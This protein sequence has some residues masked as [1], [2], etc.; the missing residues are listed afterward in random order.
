MPPKS[1]KNVFAP[2]QCIEDARQR[3]GPAY[4][5]LSLMTCTRNAVE[6]T[7]LVNT[8]EDIERE[9]SKVRKKIDREKQQL[10][11][12]MKRSETRDDVEVSIQRCDRAPRTPDE[13]N[14]L[15][16]SRL[17]KARGECNVS[18]QASQSFSVM[19]DRDL[20]SGS[21]HSQRSQRAKSAISAN[22]TTE[23]EQEELNME[24][25]Y[26][27]QIEDLEGVISS[28]FIE[29]AENNV[30][31]TKSKLDNAFRR[32]YHST[33]FKPVSFRESM[34]D[35]QVKTPNDRFAFMP[36]SSSGVKLH[37]RRVCIPSQRQCTG[38]MFNLKQENDQIAKIRKARETKGIHP[39]QWKYSP[40]GKYV[41]PAT[42]GTSSVSLTDDPNLRPKTTGKNSRTTVTPICSW[43][44]LS[45]SPDLHDK[46]EADNSEMSATSYSFSKRNEK[47]KRVSDVTRARSSLATSSLLSNAGN[48]MVQIAT[49][50]QR[51]M[52]PASSLTSQFGTRSVRPK[53]STIVQA[54]E[55]RRHLLKA[56]EVDICAPSLIYIY[57]SKYF[58]S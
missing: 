26:K 40:R 39:K 54:F 49:K 34:K 25:D 20:E 47:N 9:R 36:G 27:Q 3:L 58:I 44:V 7:K 42:I 51:E 5:D 21:S 52:S 19:A 57:R 6:L 14:I 35:Y 30:R 48:D 11:R 23:E 24:V 29:L 41:K 56:Y 4:F 13:N 10:L 37:K 38:C 31:L 17:S 8:W 55:L 32:D 28:I 50:Q 2:R 46:D 18:S 53:S 16:G 43:G 1:S 15:P 45:T 12:S 33:N 22:N